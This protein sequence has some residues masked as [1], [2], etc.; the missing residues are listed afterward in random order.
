VWKAAGVPSGL[1]EA[2]A[3]EFR[4]KSGVPIVVLEMADR[5]SGILR[6][7]ALNDVTSLQS[8]ASVLHEY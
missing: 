8:A 2:I 4:K 7:I 3:L 1:A 5:T 6:C